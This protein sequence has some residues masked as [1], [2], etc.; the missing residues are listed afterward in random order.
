MCHAERILAT[1]YIVE[2]WKANN[3]NGLSKSKHE[4]CH[5][6]L[7]NSATTNA[8]MLKKSYFTNKGEIA[9]INKHF[10]ISQLSYPE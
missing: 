9:A 8:A 4:T 2:L 3:K 1:F 10:I 5:V 6:V 7:E